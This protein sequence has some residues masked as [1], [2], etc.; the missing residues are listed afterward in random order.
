MRPFPLHPCCNN[1]VMMRTTRT[2]VRTHLSSR[3]RVTGNADWQTS[4][5]ANTP[6][7]A[8]T[9][10]L[11]RGILGSSMAAKK[12]RCRCV[13]SHLRGPD[14]HLS[15][16]LPLG[17]P[18][19]TEL[20]ARGHL[21]FFHCCTNSLLSL[22]LSQPFLDEAPLGCHGAAVGFLWQLR[23]PVVVRK[24]PRRALLDLIMCVYACRIR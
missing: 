9:A 22:C 12:T 20:P 5:T 14:G 3:I 4:R 19:T 7:E 8:L 15:D 24:T 2:S 10:P 13:P 17:T 23:A 6:S 18:P 1:L 11:Y 16:F 21:F